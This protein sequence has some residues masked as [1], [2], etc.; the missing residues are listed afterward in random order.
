MGVQ[1]A[2]EKQR[3]EDIKKTFNKN[4]IFNGMD[5]QNPVTQVVAQMSRF[6][7]ELEG[8]KDV[9]KGGKK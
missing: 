5:E 9:L 2:D 6:T 7:D 3:W 1:T 4:K 8:I